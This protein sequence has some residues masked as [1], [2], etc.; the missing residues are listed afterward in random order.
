MTAQ[1]RFDLK[2]EPDDKEL[3]ARAAA[4]MATTMAGFV[5]TVA[6]ERAI[7][8]LDQESRVNLSPRDLERF[9]SALD[10]AF[11]PN[12]ALKRALKRSNKTVRRA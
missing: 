2:L 6:K 1:A 12:P 7:E 3:L 9:A 8:I 10:G 4:V 11:T 5:R